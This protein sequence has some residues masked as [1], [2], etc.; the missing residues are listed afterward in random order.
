MK[1]RIKFERELE[2]PLHDV[3]DYFLDSDETMPPTLDDL[4][5]MIRVIAE[6]EPRDFF[7]PS[8]LSITIL[9]HSD[10]DTLTPN[11]EDNEDDN[12]ENDGPDDEDPDEEL[13]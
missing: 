12:D 11:D 9:D 6:M 1:Y 10:T 2:M 7:D 5:T 3:E 4:K 8:L 13:T